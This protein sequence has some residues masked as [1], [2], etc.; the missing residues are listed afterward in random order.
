[1]RKVKERFVYEA[2][3]IDVAYIKLESYLCQTSVTATGVPELGNGHEDYAEDEEDF[4][5]K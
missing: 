5:F 4:M 3:D 1:M 2:P